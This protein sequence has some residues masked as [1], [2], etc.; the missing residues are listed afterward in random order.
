MS[1]SAPRA[2]AGFLSRRIHLVAGKGGVGRTTVAA[3]M[4]E[5]AA[6]H[7]RRVLLTEIGHPD[8][9]DAAI[10]RPFG[11]TQ[12]A[13]DP[14]PLG[15]EGLSA[16]QVEA[17]RGHELFAHRVVPAGPL[18]RAALASNALRRFVA[19]VPSL[20]ELGLFYHLLTLLE[21]RRSDGAPEH[22]IIV[23]D[24][25]ATGHTLGLTRL[26]EIL[27][28]SL[29]DGP[30]PRAM[31]EGQAYLNDPAKSL[32]WVVTLPEYRGRGLGEA[33][34]RLVGNRAFELGARCVVLQASSQG[35]PIY[36]RMGYREITRYRWHAK[37]PPAPPR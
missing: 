2:D 27:L 32:A 16:C 30:I 26:P 13:P 11:V 10:G 7:G 36:R 3:A 23:A 15:P 35:E 29:P 33:C 25:P 12:L 19:A 22:E 18:I 8:G 1:A 20:Y 21:A 17:T 9:G 5:A 14:V 4:A 37:G 24:M 31:R 34:T 6:A 28:D